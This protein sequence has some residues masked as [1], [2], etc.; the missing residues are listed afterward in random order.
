M[1]WIEDV[2]ACGAAS[3]FFLS[4]THGH[5]DIMTDD[6]VP[7]LL[8]IILLESIDGIANSLRPEVDD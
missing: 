5:L 3:S 7:P 2:R 6:G 1:D 8:H 4:L